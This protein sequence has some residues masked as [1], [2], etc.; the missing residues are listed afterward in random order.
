MLDRTPL[1]RLALLEELYRDFND[2][3]HV[4]PDPLT[5]VLTQADPADREVTALVAAALAFGKASGIEAAAADALGRFPAPAADL[6]R[7][8]Q[9]AIEARCKGFQYRYVKT[10]ELAGLLWGVREVRRA[11]GSLE[12]AFLAG[13]N[14]GRDG[15][16]AGVGHLADRLRAAPDR[17]CGYLVPDPAKGSACK[18]LHLFL[19][20]MVRRDAV[21]PGGWTGVTP[22]QLI[23]PLDT[24][25]L[26]IAQTLGLTRRRSGGLATA[27]EVTR[28]FARWAPGDP[29]RYDFALTRLGIQRLERGGRFLEAWRAL[30][31]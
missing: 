14:G 12:A 16:L 29:V 23:V 22:A 15:P 9:R 11:H 17:A 28:A 3:R 7:L 24:H 5:P 13:F 20:W 10:A 25:M 1:S 8:N 4:A 6:A 27:L 21:D 19:R 30:P 18:R 31:E 26:R 2:R